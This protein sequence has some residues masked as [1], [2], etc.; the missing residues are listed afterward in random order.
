MYGAGCDLCDR[1]E[2]RNTPIH[3]RVGSVSSA[4]RQCVMGYMGSRSV[5]N[6]F[7]LIKSKGGMTDRQKA[8]RF[9]RVPPGSWVE[10]VRGIN[11]SVGGC[12]TDVCPVSFDISTY[13]MISRHT[14]EHARHSTVGH[15]LT[16]K[17]DQTGGIICGHINT[18]RTE[19]SNG[20]C[21]PHAA[22][23]HAPG[24]MLPDVCDS[25]SGPKAPGT[26][27]LSNLT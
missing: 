10:G 11:R 20:P 17:C 27:P 6:R 5:G 2:V 21:H 9:R 24:L 14:C 4:R 18:G 3:A 12:D 13:N 15:G 7:N 22:W 1:A 8:N 19:R 25:A 23:T 26:A 16:S